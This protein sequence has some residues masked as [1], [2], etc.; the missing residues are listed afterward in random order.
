MSRVARELMEAADPQTFAVRAKIAGNEFEMN[1]MELERALGQTI[2]DHLRAQGSNVKVKLTAPQVTCRV[3]IVNGQALIYT[4]RV[5][6]AEI[7][8]DSREK[9]GFYLPGNPAHFSHRPDINV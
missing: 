7:L 3:E 5:E 4:E 1:S 6:G 2:L 8:N 9:G